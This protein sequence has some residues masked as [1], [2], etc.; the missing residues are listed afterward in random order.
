MAKTD[1]REINICPANLLPI[2]H[3]CNHIKLAG[4]P[5]AADRYLLHPYFDTLPN[6]RWLFADLDFESGGPVLTYRVLLD[7]EVYGNLAGRLSYHF[8]KLQ[9]DRRFQERASKVLVEIESDMA[10]KFELLERREWQNIFKASPNATSY[11][12]EIHLRQQ[13]I[14]RP[15]RTQNIAQADFLVKK[16]IRARLAMASSQKTRQQG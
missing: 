4:P 3:P 2:C 6:I 14:W 9:L 15:R 12:T 8:E 1:Y 16:K 10:D 5:E 7:V 11:G 13:D